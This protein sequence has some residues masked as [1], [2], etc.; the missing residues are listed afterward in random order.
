ML[1]SRFDSIEVLA[2]RADGDCREVKVGD[3][4]GRDE[5]KDNQIMKASLP[6]SRVEAGDGAMC[7]PIPEDGTGK[8]CCS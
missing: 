8:R 7:A 2:G 6:G 4:A 5:I 1:K 3:Q